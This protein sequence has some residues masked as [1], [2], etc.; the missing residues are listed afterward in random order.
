MIDV[1]GPEE[2]GGEVFR[3]NRHCSAGALN[4]E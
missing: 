2:A 3:K 4:P 1:L